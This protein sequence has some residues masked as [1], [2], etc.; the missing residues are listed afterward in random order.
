MFRKS[1]NKDNEQAHIL[2][3]IEDCSNE[4]FIKRLKKWA[5]NPASEPELENWYQTR[6]KKNLPFVEY[7][8]QQWELDHKKYYPI[9]EEARI[10]EKNGQ[11]EKALPLY[12]EIL[13]NYTPCGTSY[14]ERPAI[15]LERLNRFEEAI[16]ICDKAINAINNNFFNGDK[17]AFEK[18]KERLYKKLNKS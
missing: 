10:L 17:S 11:I 6:H 5:N 12:I 15:I 4:D 8:P 18:R 7:K 9:Y 13:N 2:S 14:Y 16:A 1:N 3:D